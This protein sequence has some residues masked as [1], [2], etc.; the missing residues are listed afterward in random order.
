MRNRS[1]VVR[2][3]RAE[4]YARHYYVIED[5]IIPIFERMDTPLLDKRLKP[6]MKVL[7]AMM[8]RGRH[9]VRYAKRG[10][11]VT[12]NDLNPHMVALARKCAKLAGAKLTLLNKDATKLDGIKDNSFDA[13]I[14]M[15]S[16]VG[17]IPVAKRRQKAM[18]EFARTV[19]PGGMVIVHAH[20]R[21]DTLL[22]LEFYPE[23][24]RL[25]FF[26]RK[27]SFK[28]DMV[29]DYNN[30]KNM[31]NHFYSPGEFR[32]SFERA[33]LRVTEEHY[34]SYKKKRFITGPLR[35]LRA[36]GFIFIGVKR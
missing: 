31:F 20:N 25:N 32:R 12:G 33:G 7:D 29:T 18:D 17:T 11:V 6:G 14:A 34:M 23:C 28:G 22:D 2:G 27:G 30:L 13:V 24:L 35:K 19:K 1:P 3:K 26:P 8:G 16:A 4:W 10:C 36:D 9:A 15:F 5:D 21:L